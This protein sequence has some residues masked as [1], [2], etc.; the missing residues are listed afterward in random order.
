MAKIKSSKSNTR[1][2]VI[3]AKAA[4]LFREKGYSATSMRDLAEHVGVEAASLYNHIKSK[5]EILQEICFKTANQF[6]NHMSEVEASD[7]GSIAKLEAILRFH[8][9]QIIEHY[10]E[11][12]VMDREWKHLT[13]PY[14]S[15][16]QSQRRSYRQR[17][18][19]I[20]EEG[21]RKGE[22]KNIDAPTAVLIM[23]HAVSGIESWHRSVKRISAEMLEDNMV[24]ILVEGLKK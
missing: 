24:M 13:D 12:Y 16:M 18:A 3:I 1:K 8:I 2:D 20:I 9:K 19:T 11:V 4:R 17:I 5:A 10:E 6:M 23:L 15:N 21:M 7:K 22:I 14:L